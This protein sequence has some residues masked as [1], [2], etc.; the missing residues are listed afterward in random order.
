[1][2]LLLLGGTADARKICALLHSQYPY[3]QL[4]YSVA[5][6][7]RLPQVPAQVISGGF[8]Q[9][10]GLNQYCQTHNIHAIIDATHPFTTTMGAS[11][12]TSAQALAIPYW[13]FLRPAWQPQTDDRWHS[14]NNRQ[15]LL[16][17]IQGYQRILLTLGQVSV[18]ELGQLDRVPQV[19]LRTAAQPQ[20]NLPQHVKWLKAIGPFAL[21]N[22]QALLQQHRIQALACK[23]SGGDATSA[24]L[25]AAREQGLP[26]YM[27][28]R[29]RQEGVAYSAFAQ[30]LNQI[31]IWQQRWMAQPAS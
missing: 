18:Q 16:Q 7:V 30:L 12:R 15:D 21:A 9:F 2:N 28:Q 17:A 5:G 24:K 10:G 8:R 20:I 23:N 19:W 31:D 22:E 13:R 14:F 3:A 27:L 26:V 25:T 1:M 4:I 11:A 6:L 29:P